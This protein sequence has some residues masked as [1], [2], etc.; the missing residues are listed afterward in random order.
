MG[1][2]KTVWPLALENE[3]LQNYENSSEKN[4][5][6]INTKILVVINFGALHV[7]ARKLKLVPLTLIKPVLQGAGVHGNNNI[8]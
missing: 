4:K 5:R 3:I 8:N 2:A 6:F 7:V 1:E